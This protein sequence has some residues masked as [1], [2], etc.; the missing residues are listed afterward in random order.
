VGEGKICGGGLDKR[1]RHQ[2]KG[3]GPRQGTWSAIK[4][5]PTATIIRRKRGAH[6]SRYSRK[7]GI[8]GKKKN[9]SPP[10]QGPWTVARRKT[11]KERGIQSK[12]KGKLMRK[13][14]DLPGGILRSTH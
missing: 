13:E 6:K 14:K 7:K 4:E 2:E 9:A 12:T 5:P 8:S 10:K 3:K 11:N 1:A